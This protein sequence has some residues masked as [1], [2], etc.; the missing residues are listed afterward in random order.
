MRPEGADE[1]VIERPRPRRKPHGGVCS[2]SGALGHSGE[3]MRRRRSI[4]FTRVTRGVATVAVGALIGFLVPTIAADLTP[5]EE[6]AQERVAESP[7]ARQFIDAFVADD[8]IVLKSLGV[9]AATLSHSSRFKAE[10]LRVDRPVHLGS[11]VVSGGITLHAYSV[12]VVDQEG[13][14]DQLAWRV[15]SVGGTVGIIDPPGQV[16]TP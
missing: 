9:D 4:W 12:H 16:A 7:V 11:W 3:G 8:Q 14:E 13:T 10:Y 15:A 5:E 6:V 1:A 2:P